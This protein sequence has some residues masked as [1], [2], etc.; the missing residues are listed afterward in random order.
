MD[1]Y[2][3]ETIEPTKALKMRIREREHE[4]SFSSKQDKACEELS[5]SLNNAKENSFD[6]DSKINLY[7]RIRNLKLLLNNVKYRDEKMDP[8]IFANF[9]IMENL[10]E[11]VENSLQEKDI[12][13]E[14]IETLMNIVGRQKNRR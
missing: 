8:D 1:A 13:C 7:L 6:R 2:K 12:I 9:D 4:E 3:T 10:F 14:A 5:D 11:I